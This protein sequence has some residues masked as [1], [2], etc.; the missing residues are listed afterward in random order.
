LQS[1]LQSEPQ[2]LDLQLRKDNVLKVLSI[3]L[4]P[5]KQRRVRPGSGGDGAMA[6]SVMEVEKTTRNKGRN[7]I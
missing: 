3:R 2:I 6:V 5:L 7:R 1:Y 4:T